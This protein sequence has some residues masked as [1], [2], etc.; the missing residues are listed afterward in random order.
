MYV[1]TAY[2]AEV[3]HFKEVYVM[4]IVKRA[5]LYSAN[6][7]V[8]YSR[9]KS[10]KS[11]TCRGCQVF[12]RHGSRAP[13]LILPLSFSRLHY[14]WFHRPWLQTSRQHCP[15]IHWHGRRHPGPAWTDAC[16]ECGSSFRLINTT[17]LPF[18]YYFYIL[19]SW[20]EYL[21][22]CFSLTKKTFSSCIESLL[23][24]Q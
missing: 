11:W 9:R 17:V 16:W 3:L 20:C 7:T 18:C 24:T 14:T 19:K 1:H 10:L 21:L 13:K 5:Q 6:P 23:A 8:P 22:G 4:I 2:S 12:Y 15:T